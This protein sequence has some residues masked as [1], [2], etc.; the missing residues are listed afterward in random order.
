MW[1]EIASTY[2]ISRDG[3]T[4]LNITITPDMFDRVSTIESALPAPLQDLLN[5][6]DKL[7]KPKLGHCVTTTANLYLQ[8]GA[9]P[10][11]CK[12]HKLPFALK[13]VVGG[14]L[15]RLERQGV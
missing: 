12:P 7:F 8:E 5:I 10:K 6:Y 4:K 13:P 14:E 15:D 11:Y 2:V 9:Q 1:H 3:L